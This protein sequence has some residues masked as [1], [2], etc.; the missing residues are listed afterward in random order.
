MALFL[1]SVYAVV[2]GYRVAIT[3]DRLT[4][5]VNSVA[6]TIA[7]CG[8]PLGP[9]GAGV[10]L[11]TVSSRATV[12]VFAAILL[13]LAAGATLAPSMRNAPD[14]AELEELPPR[15]AISPEPIG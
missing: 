11:S 2:I 3:P 12:A 5:R 13:L 7:L 4:G 1:P 15:P 8:A 9:L 10:L 6:R 14:L